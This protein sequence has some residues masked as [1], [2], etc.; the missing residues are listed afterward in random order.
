VLIDPDSANTEV[1]LAALSSLAESVE[2]FGL[3]YAIDPLDTRLALL[4]TLAVER[5]PGPDDMFLLSMQYPPDHKEGAPTCFLDPSGPEGEARLH[6]A[7]DLL[8]LSGHANALDAAFGRDKALCAR[9]GTTVEPADNRAFPCFA[10]GQCFRQPRLHRD[11]K[12]ARGLMNLREVKARVIALAGCHTASV[13]SSWFDPGISLAYQC[14]QSAATAAFVTSGLSLER[15]ELNFLF[16]TL[17]SEGRP[18]GEVARELNRVRFEVHGHATSL[19]GLGP[20]LLL[21]NPCL[22]YAGSGPLMREAR[23]TSGRSFEIEIEGIKTN[24]QRGVVVR[25]DLPGSGTPFLS[26][27]GAPEGLWCRGVLH[28]QGKSNSLYLWLGLPAGHEP[29]LRGKLHIEAR[30][31][32]STPTVR[33]LQSYLRQLPFWMISLE[34]FRADSDQ[35]PRCAARLAATLEQLPAASLGLSLA[36]NIIR[37]RPGILVDARRMG[38][39][40]EAALNQA[41]TIAHVLLDSLVEICCNFGTMHS[42]GW[43]NCFE[44]VG[45]VGPMDICSC[46]TAP[47]WGQRSR[48][49]GTDALE[50]VEYQCA[51]CGPVGEDDGRRLLRLTR[52]AASAQQ[53]GRLRCRCTC[54]APQDERVQ[55][56]AV[57]VLEGLYESTSVVSKPMHATVEPD[58]SIEIEMELDLPASLRPG[59][60]P[61]AVVGIVN[62]A[63]CIVRQ[64]IEV[65]V[66][67]PEFRADT[68]GNEQG[69]KFTVVKRDRTTSDVIVGA[70]LVGTLARDNARVAWPPRTDQGCT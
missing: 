31:T 11:I 50:R 68:A 13:G 38:A 52:L 19:P 6:Q 56:L 46:G 24:Q 14:Q 21:G 53:G 23:W 20:F 48:F 40:D 61:F 27:E 22:R 34:S 35:T 43:E 55:F 10:S 4:K 7:C 62:G 70:G 41:N 58:S 1:V 15:L 47:L 42:A 66:G 32:A 3:I 2:C 26:L 33:A 36:A 18:F 37:S 54:Q 63:S 51:R 16:M 45:V 8:V 64:M 12:D 29:C 28:T 67:F 44:R 65:R 39:L 9:A 25:V 60:Y 69:R 49:V 59:M 17:L 30:T 57:L 5:L